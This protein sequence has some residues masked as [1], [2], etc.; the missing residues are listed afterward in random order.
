MRITQQMLNQMAREGMQTNLRRMADLQRQAAAGKRVGRPGDDPAAVEQ[1]LGFRARIDAGQAVLDNIATNLDWLN[2]TDK[3]LGDMSTLLNRANV[4]ALRG[5]SE[6]LGPDERDALATEVEGVLE[7]AIAVGNTRHGDAHLFS[8]FKIDTPAFSATLDPV[9][10]RITGAAYNGDA[11]LI[12]RQAEP[13]TDVAI[14]LPG[15]TLFGDVFNGLVAL[16]D[17]LRASPFLAGDV[18]TAM[19][20]LKGRM[21]SVLD[22]QA[23][24]GTKARRLET[25]ADRLEN[26]QLGLR[27]LLS[28]AEDADLAEVLSQL[29]Q[30]Q[31]V[32]QTALAINGRVLH[33]SLLDFLK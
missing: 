28:K 11:G 30:Q 6:S 14:N 18:T 1:A 9:T 25:T 8:G 31:F 16:R 23:A 3:A 21:D 26:S 12:L 20:D 5:A 4:L 24:I 2:A 27:E 17:A 7:Q 10:G 33:T 19:A 29:S 32:Y 13:G 22:A 15:D